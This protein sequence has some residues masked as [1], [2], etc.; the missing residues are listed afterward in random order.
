MHEL[1]ERLF[2]VHHVLVEEDLVPEAGVEEVQ[3]GVLGAADVEVHRQP[4][5]GRLL[6]PRLGLVLS[7]R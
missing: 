5:L 3:D 2:D 7:G 4:A 1:L 6:A